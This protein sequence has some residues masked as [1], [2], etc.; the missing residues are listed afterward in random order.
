MDGL[1]LTGFLGSGKTTEGLR[2]LAETLSRGIPVAYIVNDFGRENI[3]FL[4]I[5]RA[6]P[7]IPVEDLRDA[8][9]GCNGSEQFY[10]SVER[11]YEKGTKFLIVEPTG[12]LTGDEMLQIGKDL[13]KWCNFKVATLI[14]VPRL[15]RQGGAIEATEEATSQLKLASIVGFTWCNSL[16]GF[17]GPSDE[18]LFKAYELCG[19]YAPGKRIFIL[20]DPGDPE[21]RPN[22]DFLDEVFE[23]LKRPADVDWESVRIEVSARHCDHHHD[24]YI[25]WS[26][27]VRDDLTMEDFVAYLGPVL[28]L[29]DRAKGD[30][31]H[32][33]FDFVEGSW[34]FVSLPAAG[35]QLATI[36]AK[37]PLADEFLQTI[38]AGAVNP[39][40]PTVEE[41]EAA[42][43]ELLRE[44]APLCPSIGTVLPLDG[45]TYLA[46]SLATKPGIR[47]ELRRQAIE[48]IFERL[49][50]A[51]RIIR[52]IGNVH[53]SAKRSAGAFLAFFAENHQAEMS[54]GILREVIAADPVSLLAEGL[55]V[56][57]N[58]GTGTGITGAAVRP[59]FLKKVMDFART[60]TPD[61]LP[62]L[63]QAFEHCGKIAAISDKE[64]WEELLVR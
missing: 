39:I 19:A 14:R 15:L 16:D 49:I 30:I 20:P 63:K 50:G 45:Q 60:N 11:L 57:E 54:V 5:R 53:A 46:Y 56:L 31:G 64:V 44:T 41:T 37:K 3:D 62:L 34:K 22:K 40:S 25:P 4:R 35:S 55:A 27:R 6:Y 18:R 26:F 7:E 38:S 33:S 8:R 58:I 28:P 52:E 59:S 12:I 23:I 36:I 29:V 32:E 24:P 42:I 48:A 61:A 51:C 43:E 10:A 1:F 13:K 2:L 9:I 17:Q 21:A 47:M